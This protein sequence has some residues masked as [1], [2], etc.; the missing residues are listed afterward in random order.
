M[1]H[2]DRLNKG[3]VTD[4]EPP[5][6][7]VEVDHMEE[8]SQ[9]EHLDVS[10]NQLPIRA[11]SNMPVLAELR[12]ACNNVVKIG[13]SDPPGFKSLTVSLGCARAR[14]QLTTRTSH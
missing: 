1:D 3:V 6:N 2:P 4:C 7:A 14:P 11:F 5:Y 8:F 10:G 9:L 13:L 12:M